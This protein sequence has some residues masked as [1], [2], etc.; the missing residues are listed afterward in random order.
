MP[1]R[2]IERRLRSLP[3]HKSSV[4]VGSTS[5]SVAWARI[6][7]SALRFGSHSTINLDLGRHPSATREWPAEKSAGFAARV[8]SFEDYADAEC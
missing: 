7:G 6:A 8:S 4:E 3:N 5:R 2:N 1:G